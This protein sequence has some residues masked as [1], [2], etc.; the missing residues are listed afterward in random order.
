MVG[1]TSSFWPS[2]ISHLWRAFV[3]TALI[4]A[5]KLLKAWYGQEMVCLWSHLI[6]PVPQR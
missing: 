1:V 6:F 4:V 3:L 5:T 2:F